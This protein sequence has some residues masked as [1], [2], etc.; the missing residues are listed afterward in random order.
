MIDESTREMIRARLPGLVCLSILSGML[1]AGLWPFHSPRNAVTWLENQNGV[2]LGRHG[3]IVSSGTFQTAGLEDSSSL[4][5]WLQPGL[6]S[7][8]RTI[9]S[10]YK[11]ENP[12]QFSLHQY[13]SSLVLQHDLVLQHLS[14]S[15]QHRIGIE[16][17]FGPIKPPFITITSSPQQTA[18][19]VNG[20]LARLFPQFRL[21]K[22]FTG[23]LVIGASP[24]ASDTWSGQLLGLAI[25]HQELTAVQVLQHYDTWTKQGCPDRSGNGRLIALYL[26]SEHAGNTVHNAIQP[27]IDLNIPKRFTLLHQPFLQPFWKEYEWGWQNWGDSILINIVGFIPLGFFFC[28]YWS[29]RRPMKRPAVVTTLLGL[30]VSLTIE[31]LQAYLPTR[32]SGTTDLMTNT[33]GTFLGVSLYGSKTGRALLAKVYGILPSG[34]G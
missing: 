27:G 25:Y 28:A 1:V 22:D 9:L 3:T 14:Q 13:F 20:A 7:A 12:L 31:V 16:G 8:S 29:Y 2:Y 34:N 32:T 15:R 33:F 18:I 6:P 24:V 21:E 26:F 11:P 17:V 30:A 19:Y 4:E 10:F 5:I 23:Q